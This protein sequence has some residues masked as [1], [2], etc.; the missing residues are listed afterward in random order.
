V[1]VELSSLLFVFL[2]MV[3]YP[4][5]ANLNAVKLFDLVG[6]L[7]RA[8]I[9]LQS[10]INDLLFKFAYSWLGFVSSF[11]RFVMGMFWAASTLAL[12]S[13]NFSAYGRLMHRYH[14]CNFG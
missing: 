7:F 5:M 3:L 12:I 13:A 14:F 10:S 11:K 4:F 9:F 6:Y 2:N 1:F 8:P